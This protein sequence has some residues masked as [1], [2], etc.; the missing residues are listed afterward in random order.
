MKFF[1]GHKLEFHATMDM[2]QTRLCPK[3]F[4][5]VLHAEKFPNEM[6]LKASRQVYHGNLELRA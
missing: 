2:N 6:K 1:H 5:D 3:W 4:T